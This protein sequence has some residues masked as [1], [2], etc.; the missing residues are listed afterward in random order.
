MGSLL[1]DGEAGE[2]FQG[3]LG[4]ATLLLVCVAEQ[5]TAL[6]VAERKAELSDERGTLRLT[7]CLLPWGLPKSTGLPG[8][9]ERK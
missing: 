7:I 4:R 3:E 1:R 5:V 8:R 2:V 6:F 9:R